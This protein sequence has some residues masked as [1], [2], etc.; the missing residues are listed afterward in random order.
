MV[1]VTSPPAEVSRQRDPLCFWHLDY[2][3]TM[4]ALCQH[5]TPSIPRLWLQHSESESVD[6][7]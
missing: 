5:C 1:S 4:A 6:R 3:G 7:I 2:E